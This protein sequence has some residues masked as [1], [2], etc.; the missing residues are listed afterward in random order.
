MR[1]SICCTDT[2]QEPWLAGLQAALPQAE[3][4]VWAP[5]APAA[6]Y[7]VVWAPPQQFLDE[8][9]QL[10]A[11]FNI[12]AGVDALMQHGRAVAANGVD[13]GGRI[14]V[15]LQLGEVGVA[16][17]IEQARTRTDQ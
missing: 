10:K 4:S 16:V 3:V 9:P 8:Q 17:F 5:G 13:L 11:L 6:D 1:I 2:K 12:G 7:A 15:G 14:A